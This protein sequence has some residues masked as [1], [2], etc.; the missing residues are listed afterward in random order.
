MPTNN[1]QGLE[2]PIFVK[3][4]R[5]PEM[6]YFPKPS[7]LPRPRQYVSDNLINLYFDQLHH[8]LPVLYKPKFMARYKQLT[9]GSGNAATDKK[10]L[11]VFYAVCACASGL[12]VPEGQRPDFPGLEYYQRSLV[13]HYSTTGEASVERV[14]ALALLSMCAGGFNTQTQAWNFAGQAVRAAQDLGETLQMKRI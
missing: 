3:G 11:S 10:F 9:T 8:T 5:W 6:P 14:Q 4:S 2:L 7:D 12:I 1:E 13:L